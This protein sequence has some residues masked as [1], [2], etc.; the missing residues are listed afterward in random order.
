MT[1]F[2]RWENA[3]AATMHLGIAG[4][5][6]LQAQLI[7]GHMEG[8]EAIANRMFEAISELSDIAELLL[9]A[10]QEDRGSA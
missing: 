6:V 10:A 3:T 7:V 1:D 8:G 5:Q 2:T 9:L 4:E